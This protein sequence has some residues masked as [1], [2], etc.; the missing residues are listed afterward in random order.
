MRREFIN[1]GTRSVRNPIVAE[2]C[3][4]SSRVSTVSDWH[5]CE[6]IGRKRATA[7]GR[8]GKQG[9]PKQSGQRQEQ[10]QDRASQDKVRKSMGG[11]EK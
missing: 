7:W 9:Q 3:P 4:R 10:D 6:G 5:R 1:G 8:T 2:G 11:K